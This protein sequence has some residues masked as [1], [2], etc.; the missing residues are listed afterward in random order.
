MEKSLDAAEPLGILH[1]LYLMTFTSQGRHHVLQVLGLSNH[2]DVLLPFI[3]MTGKYASFYKIS[4]AIGGLTPLETPPSLPSPLQILA[5]SFNVYK[6]IYPMIECLLESKVVVVLD[7]HFA[8][9]DD[10]RGL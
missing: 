1:N 4:C 6:V 5:S 9:S 10:K 2:V 7:K 8:I 3:R